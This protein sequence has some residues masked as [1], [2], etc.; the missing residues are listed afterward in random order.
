MATQDEE[1]AA[2]VAE[3]GRSV[4]A[5]IGGQQVHLASTF[6]SPVSARNA[7]SR[8]LMWPRRSSISWII[9]RADEGAE[10]AKPER[11]EPSVL[12]GDQD[13]GVDARPRKT[14]TASTPVAADPIGAPSGATWT[15]Y[16]R[17][18]ARPAH[19]VQSSG[20]N[21]TDRSRRL[22]EFRRQFRSAVTPIR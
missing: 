4:D 16:E 14:S 20:A 7:C 8:R 17:H 15:S 18:S 1:L 5:A 11:R 6:A 2:R 9:S 19:K 3:N 12:A 10:I 22:K 21:S 13:L